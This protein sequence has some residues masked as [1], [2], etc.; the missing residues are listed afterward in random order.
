MKTYP[1]LCFVNQ[2]KIFVMFDKTNL[3]LVKDSFETETTKFQYGKP[4]RCMVIEDNNTKQYM[5]YGVVFDEVEFNSKFEFLHDIVMREWVELGLIT[6]EH[7]PMSKPLFANQLDVHTYGKG[8]N[9]YRCGFLG[10]PKE[11][12]Y[13]FNANSTGDNKVVLIEQ[14]YS[15]YINIINGNVEAFDNGS[16]VRGNSGYPLSW[17]EIYW[18]KSNEILV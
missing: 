16:V 7:K 13:Q 9:A 15:N 11:C 12:C 4:Y 5:V 3:V 8:K 17:N 10:K 6:A 14:A 1:Y 2:L 18:K